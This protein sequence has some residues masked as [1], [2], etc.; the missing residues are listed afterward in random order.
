VHDVEPGAD[1]ELA[2][3]GVHVP[4]VMVYVLLGHWAQSPTAVDPYPRMVHGFFGI[5]ML[6]MT[7]KVAIVP[8][9]S[10]G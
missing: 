1:A 3:Q 10:L 7:L 6:L 2:G 4:G 8:M 9:P 5:C